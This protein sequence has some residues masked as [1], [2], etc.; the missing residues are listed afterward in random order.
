[1]NLASMLIEVI[2]TNNWLPGFSIFTP[3]DYK[4]MLITFTLITSNSDFF[5]LTRPTIEIK[6]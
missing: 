3:M 5:K 6:N 1:M 2:R 4:W